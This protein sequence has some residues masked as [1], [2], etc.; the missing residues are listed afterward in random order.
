MCPDCLFGQVKTCPYIYVQSAGLHWA[1]AIRPYMPVII[2]FV[3]AS[4]RRVSQNP[5]QGKHGGL[6][7]QYLVYAL[8]FCQFIVGVDPRVDPKN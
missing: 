7:L 5:K 6:P 2:E 8:Y 1:N 3:V 4:P